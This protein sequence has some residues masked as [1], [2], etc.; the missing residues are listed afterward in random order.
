MNN[1][2]YEV[3][4]ETLEQVNL[5]KNW[6]SSTTEYIYLK[7]LN[8]AY[9]AASS[10]AAKA[11]GFN[12][13]QE[14]IGKTDLE[15]HIPEAAKL[16][17]E[18][19]KEVLETKQTYTGRHWIEHAE[20]G[21]LLIESVKSPLYDS[22]GNIIGVQGISRDVTQR[23]QMEKK[24]K[25]QQSQ[26]SSIVNNIPFAMWL[27]DTE[28]NFLLVNDRCEDLY[29]FNKKDLIGKKV[30]Q[31]LLDTGVI[32]QNYADKLVEED[33]QI[34]AT[35]E[36]IQ[37]EAKVRIRGEIKCMQII[38]APVLDSDGNC[39]GLLGMAIDVT[40]RKNY[41]KLLV[42]SKELAENSN[43]I[44]SEFL[45]NMSHEIRTPM[46]GII[47]FLQLLLDTN[48][49]E[50]Q[51][52]FA[53]EAKK[54]AEILLALLSDI[55]DLSRVEAGKMSMEHISFNLR[56]T[57][58]DV[59][60]L[61]SA[62]AALKGL[63]I[64]VL[65]HSNIP[66]KVFG[67]P[68]RLRQVLNNLISNAIKF[69]NEGEI[70]IMVKLQEHRDSKAKIRF[71]VQDTGIGIAKET[72]EKIFEA[73]TQA[74]S[75]ATRQYGG[76]GLGLAISKNIVDMVQGTITVESE[77]GKGSTFA[78]T[79]E[80]DV[81]HSVEISL[82]NGHGIENKNILIVDDN[83]TNINVL[84]HYLKPYSCNM[85][86]V[87]NPDSALSV[88]KADETKFDIILTDYCMPGLDGIEFAKKVREIPQYKNV[89]II[90]LTSRAQ[91]GDYSIVRKSSLSG[92][93]PKPVRKNEF[94]ECVSLALKDAEHK[95]VWGEK[96]VVT[97]HTIKELYR[98]AKAKIL[99][100]EDNLLN[101]KLMTKLLNKVGFTCDIANNGKEALDAFSANNYDIIFM[102]C[103]MPVMDGYETTRK[104]RETNKDIPIIALTA[105]TLENDAEKCL[106]AGMTDYVSK[107]IDNNVF[108]EKISKY[109]PKNMDE[110]HNEPDEIKYNLS[111]N[112]ADIEFNSVV[113]HVMNDLGFSREEVVEL[114]SEYI[115]DLKIMLPELLKTVEAG[116]SEAVRQTAHSIK[117]ASGNLR[118]EYIH[119]LAKTLENEAK[120]D[121]LNNAEAII[122][123]MSA[124][125]AYF[126]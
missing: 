27:K 60:T 110:Y 107:P 103:Q 24:I 55:L 116:D 91:L 113:E 69:T 44:K 117:G 48:L 17:V 73:F 57:V 94:L 23:H 28:D 106:A 51:I 93:L 38:K 50:E 59:A 87:L 111:E 77:L 56:Y 119:R 126:K 114:L 83:Q 67:D 62:D 32:T 14:M 9:R 1:E 66:E 96:Q 74:D 16:F 35:H 71:E 29:G 84:K 25:E 121:K 42:E 46:N 65:C 52:D 118:L 31:T 99:L 102:D 3:D 68:R 122:N 41:E 88:L 123:S 34:I 30:I 95:A 18:Q 72:Q 105:C 115:K 101:Q 36:I 54:S 120:N 58:E 43:R 125:I 85:M 63:E 26:L 104:I 11:M 61:A 112:N 22:E 6:L 78:F 64:N 124:Y 2:V 21:S 97:K 89:P 19:D 39:F 86:G 75:S 70:N 40:E 47:G 10:A 12:S 108:M 92:Y 79:A 4:K 33:K 80:F 53:Q 45:A 37:E 98:E 13:P 82:Q 7:D 15:I 90:L 49:D 109:I 81:D 100:V 5:W 76:T 8:G 20:K